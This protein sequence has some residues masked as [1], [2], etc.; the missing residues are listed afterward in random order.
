MVASAAKYGLVEPTVEVLTLAVRE[1]ARVG[2]STARA[3]AVEAL[4]R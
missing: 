2:E 1:S 4:K 3:A